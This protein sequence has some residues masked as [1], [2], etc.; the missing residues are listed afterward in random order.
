MGADNT[1]IFWNAVNSDLWQVPSGGGTPGPLTTLDEA[2]GEVNFPDLDN[3]C[4]WA[5]FNVRESLLDVENWMHSLLSCS[6]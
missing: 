4:F 3:P 6:A 1:I 5:L 2:Q